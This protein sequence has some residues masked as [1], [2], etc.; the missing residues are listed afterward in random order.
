MK[1][2]QEE[3]ISKW[4]GIN[5]PYPPENFAFVLNSI[6]AKSPTQFRIEYYHDLPG[7]NVCICIGGL[8]LRSTAPTILEALRDVVGEFV[9]HEIEPPPLKKVKKGLDNGPGG[10][11][12]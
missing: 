4:L 7:W 1:S 12:R 6:A 10:V 2:E 9:N 5:F 3:K 8:K 11:V